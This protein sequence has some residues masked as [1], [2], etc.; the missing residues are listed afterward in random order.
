MFEGK[1]EAVGVEGRTLMELCGEREW[2]RVGGRAEDR[3]ELEV[4]DVDDAFEWVCTWWMLRMEETEDEVDL[5]PRRPV[6]ERLYDECGVRG[7]GERES[8]CRGFVTR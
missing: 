1:A 4:E 6:E 3:T 7:D 5:R 2:R 8:R